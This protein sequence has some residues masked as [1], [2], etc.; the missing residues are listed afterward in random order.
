MELIEAR[1]RA[2]MS[3]KMKSIFIQNMSH[4]IRTPLNAIVGFSQ[5]MLSPDMELGKEEREEFGNII[6]TNSELLTTLV[7]DIISLSELESG[8]YKTNL[9][10]VN[11][12][13][14]CNNALTTV[15]HRCKTGVEMV[16]DKQLDDNYTITTDEQRV[17]QVLI[18]YLTNAIKY[19]EKGS[20]TISAK[21]DEAEG[22]VTFSVTDTGIGIPLDKQK[23]IFER[24]M[25]LDDFHQGTG[26]GLNI[27][28]LIAEKLGG[29]VGI[30]HTYTNGSRFLLKL[31]N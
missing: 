27:C 25:K 4:E 18:N 14:L 5:L 26:L 11:V 28:S 24:F 29:E 8:R 17:S 21:A 13:R 6:R 22:I 10:K 31:K 7:G 15:K 16:F 20:I 2:E 12:N 3:D 9:H 1:K 23:D 19:T 30:D